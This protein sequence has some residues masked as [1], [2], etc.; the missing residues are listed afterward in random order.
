MGL[1]AVPVGRQ[2][3]ALCLAVALWI[4]SLSSLILGD[5]GGGDSAKCL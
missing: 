2:A 3:L 5:F 1:V 4:L